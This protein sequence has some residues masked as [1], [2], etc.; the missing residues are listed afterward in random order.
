MDNNTLLVALFNAFGAYVERMTG[1]TFIA[2]VKD[3]EGNIRHIQASNVHITWFDQQG[4]VVLPGV[5]TQGYA[6]RRCPLHEGLNDSGT[7]LPLI[8]ERTAI[9]RHDN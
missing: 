3:D 4:E 5:E 7:E 2:C 6:D 9:H 8:V 1:E